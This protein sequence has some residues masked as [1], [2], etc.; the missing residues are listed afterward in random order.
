MEPNRARQLKIHKAV[1]GVSFNELAN[2]LVADYLD[3][4]G[5]RLLSEAGFEATQQQYE[6]ALRKLA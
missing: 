6:V 5:R 4:E 2:K 1:T 3:G